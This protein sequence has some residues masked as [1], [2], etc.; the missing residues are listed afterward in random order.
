MVCLPIYLRPSTDAEG[1]RYANY[2]APAAS[3]SYR[4]VP[5]AP[6]AGP[7]RN[8]WASQ[9]TATAYGAR[10][11]VLQDWKPNPMWKPI[12]ALTNMEALPGMLSLETGEMVA[13]ARYW[14]E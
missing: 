13:D 5:A 8:G 3:S 2:A 7:S 11:P 9:T 4:P 12:K 1:G 6:A 10:T 14:T